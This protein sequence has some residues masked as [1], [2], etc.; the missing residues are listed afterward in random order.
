MR[1]SPLE[2]HVVSSRYTLRRSV[3]LHT[4]SAM[5][6]VEHTGGMSIGS[7]IIENGE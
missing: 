2:A 1:P 6:R 5:F 3:E 7:P 4:A